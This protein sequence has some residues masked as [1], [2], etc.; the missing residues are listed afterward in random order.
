[1]LDVSDV[2]KR[3]GDF[4][5]LDHVSLEIGDN[6]LFSIVGPSGSGKTTL[7][8]CIAGLETPDEGSIVVSGEDITYLKPYRRNISTVFQ[9]LALFPHKN[10]HNNVA[11]GMRKKGIDD[12]DERVEDLLSL[13]ELE[14]YGSRQIGKLSGGERQRVA[15]ARSIAVEPELLLLDEPLASV[16]QKLRLQL[17]KDLQELQ[18]RLEQTFI[19]V[20]HDQN[21]AMSISGRVAVI[22]EGRIEQVGRPSDLYDDP[23][24]FFVASFIGESN[25]LTG[26]VNRRNRTVGVVTSEDGS[27]E[28]SGTLGDDDINEGDVVDAEVKVEKVEANP[29]GPCDNQFEGRV[30]RNSYR[31]DRTKV[32]FGVNGRELDALSSD[33]FKVG[34]E[35][36]VGWANEDCHLFAQ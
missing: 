22:N 5:A 12:I 21:T 33:R 25:L 19:Y 3:F 27:L 11:Y 2:V 30:V 15:L 10:V 9:N 8:R 35:V 17:E 13:V 34:D 7:L 1:M 31:G 36:T 32:T 26:T 28:F 20:T 18:E 23:E 4:V 14:G 29:D 6:E 24:T 16:D